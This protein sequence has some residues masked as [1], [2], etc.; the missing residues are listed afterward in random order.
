MIDGWGISCEIALRW[1]PLDLTD[2]KSTLDQVMAWCHQAT[3][4]Y[5]NHCWLRSMS[6]YGITK[7]PW[8]YIIMDT[9]LMTMVDILIFDVK[10]NHFCDYMSKTRCGVM[11]LNNEC[12]LWQ[13]SIQDVHVYVSVCVLFLL[14]IDVSKILYCHPG[15][16]YLDA[17][18]TAIQMGRNF[19]FTV[20]PFLAMV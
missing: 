10:L 9:S 8:V 5:L 4:H 12:M 2:E 1:M 13:V 11:S 15:A 6:P 17:F 7:P 18:S 20:I 14:Y 3:S 16:H 19:N